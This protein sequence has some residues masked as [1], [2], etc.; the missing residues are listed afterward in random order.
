MDAPRT[1]RRCGTALDEGLCARCLLELGLGGTPQELD[2]PAASAPSVRFVPPTAAELAPLFPDLEIGELLGHG[3]M[4]AVFRARQKKLERDVALKVL[5]KELSADRKFAER[6]LREARALARLSH[7]N[8][9]A[10][11]DY[12]ETGGVCWLLLEYVDGANLRA[13]LKSGRMDSRT[14]LALVRELC[15]ALQ[16]AHDE[17]VVH[18][19]I[20]PENVLVD[21]RGRAKVADFGL[22]KLIGPAQGA[23]LT[24]EGQVMGT[25]H[26]MA[27]EQ[28]ER[29]REV[30]HR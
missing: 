3:G 29:P 19:D 15:D 8:I 9:V 6:F 26:Y 30:D 28:I 10:V 25:P 1:C 24:R 11:H 22:A 4:G 27:P 17:G 21:R 5:P 7:P 13:I 23:D 12:G 16:Y 18:R 2:E 20:K 14:A